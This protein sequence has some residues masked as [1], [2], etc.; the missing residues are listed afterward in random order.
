MQGG[1]TASTNIH[2][3]PNSSVTLDKVSI[4]AFEPADAHSTTGIVLEDSSSHAL[5]QNSD[6]SLD[7]FSN[8]PASFEVTAIDGNTGGL[9]VSR[10][11]IWL[12]ADN[13]MAST[14]VKGVVV[15][16]H[17]T[18]SD[19]KIDCTALSSAG[20]GAASG[21]QI[22]SSQPEVTLRNVFLT[23]TS[24]GPL[25]YSV[26]VQMPAGGGL[27][28]LNSQIN[29]DEAGIDATGGEVRLGG[30]MLSS[31]VGSATATC[32]ASYTTGFAPLSATCTP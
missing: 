4:F 28:A 16:N 22:D 11:N 23:T 29:G 20:T 25:Q 26:G 32:A 30:T 1:L 17:A 19:S 31:L 14:F 12:R 8:T 21:L 3:G 6:I 2:I 9:N 27:T 15:D 10:T 18:I 24:Q 13:A 5:I 7:L